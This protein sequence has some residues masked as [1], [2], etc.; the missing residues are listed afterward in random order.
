MYRIHPHLSVFI[1]SGR[2]INPVSK[3]NWEGSGVAPD[4]K[5]KAADALRTAERLALGE[6]LK[7]PANEAHA[8]RLRMRLAELK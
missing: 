2:A 4:V 5:V 1:P 6:L 8:Q 3:T 7:S